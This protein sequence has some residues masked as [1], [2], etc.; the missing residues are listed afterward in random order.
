MWTDEIDGIYVINLEKREQRLKDV[1]AELGKYNI[2]FERIVAVP[3]KDGAIG[4]MKTVQALW[5]QVLQTDKKRILILE[6]DVKFISNPNEV[7]P[8]VLSQLPQNF[9]LLY[10]GAYL[11][12]PPRKKISDTLYQLNSALTTH[13][14]LYSRKAIKQLLPYLDKMLKV[15]NFPMALDM[16]L[17]NRVV[18]EHNSYI[19]YPQLATQVVAFSDIRKKKVDYFEYIEKPYNEWINGV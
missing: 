2:P 15:K 18:K 8:L 10:L 16:I 6:D 3:S 9:D 1:T 13:A 11:L 7:M 14:I 12:Q 4:L 17:N 19:T 5:Y